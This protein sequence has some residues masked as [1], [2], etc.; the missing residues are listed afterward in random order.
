[1]R[2]AKEKIA[3]LESEIRKLTEELMPMEKDERHPLSRD[4]PSLASREGEVASSRYRLE[5]LQNDLG[6]L[7]E[8]ESGKLDLEREKFCKWAT[9]SL[10]QTLRNVQKTVIG[11]QAE[12]AKINRAKIL[13][14]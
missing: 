10:S 5:A 4:F 11:L 7:R 8:V 2:Q 14:S 3:A 12:M 1:M 13:L 6:I 9:E